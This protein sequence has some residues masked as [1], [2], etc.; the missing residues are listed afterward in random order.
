MK[1]L[2]IILSLVISFFL[3]LNLNS[4]TENIDTNNLRDEKILNKFGTTKIEKQIEIKKV[5]TLP[6]YIKKDILARGLD[7]TKLNENMWNSFLKKQKHNDFKE[8]IKLIDTTSLL[9]QAAKKSSKELIL[10]LID[11]GYDIN[12]NDRGKTPLIYA[13]EANASV[14]FVEF[15]VSNGANLE[16]NKDIEGKW[17]A[18]NF[19]LG[20][21]KDGFNF[22]EDLVEYLLQNNF[23]FKK[24]HF[25][26]LLKIES[27]KKNKYLKDYIDTLEVNEIYS[28]KINIG[29]LE[30]FLNNKIDDNNIRY[31]LD[32]KIDFETYNKSNSVAILFGAVKNHNI[33]FETFSRLMDNI[34]LDVNQKTASNVTPLMISTQNGDFQKIEYLLK[35]GANI[36]IQT[37]SGKDVYDYLNNSKIDEYKKLEIKTLLDRYKK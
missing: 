14:E 9:H 26:S 29:Y 11:M 27:D 8:F 2:I 22:K 19:A 13:I 17:D 12:T 18:L 1:I 21:I 15:L 10:K 37:H 23:E 20:T 3:G 16:I 28:E 36:S 35:K 24:K 30:Y 32:T 25:L 34:N 5:E 6:F 31:L 4:K 7:V 33:S